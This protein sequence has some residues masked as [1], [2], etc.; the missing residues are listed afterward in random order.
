MGCSSPKS[1]S[2]RC[3]RCK[4]TIHDQADIEDGDE[5][6]EDV[7]YMGT[8][9][10]MWQSTVNQSRAITEGQSAVVYLDFVKDVY[11]VSELLKHNSF[12]VGKYTEQM[13]VEE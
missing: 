3:K 7:V 11:E 12:K 8:T 10:S 2:Q 6:D 5:N 13:S 9:S 4:H 1:K